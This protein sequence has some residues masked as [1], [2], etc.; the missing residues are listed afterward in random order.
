MYVEG[1]ASI[2]YM[3][4]TAAQVFGAAASALRMNCWAAGQV[5][6]EHGREVV[7]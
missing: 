2:V 1:A 6:H 7:T 3:I 5:H 4:E